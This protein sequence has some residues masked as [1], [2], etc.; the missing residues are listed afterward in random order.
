MEMLYESSLDETD[1]ELNKK[2]SPNK[3]IKRHKRKKN[4]TNSTMGTVNATVVEK[5]TKCSG[6]HNLDLAGEFWLKFP[7]QLLQRPGYEH[8][9]IENKAIHTKN[10]SEN[11]YLYIKNDV[12]PV[13]NT[14]CSKLATD[15][16][17]SAIYDRATGCPITMPNEYLN[18]S[19]LTS[20][21]KDYHEK[22]VQAKLS[23][24]NKDLQ[25]LLYKNKI[26]MYIRFQLLIAN[27]DVQQIRA[28]MQNCIKNKRGVLY[29]IKQISLAA[30][31]VYQ[32]KKFS[33]CDIDL[34]ILVLRIGGPCLLYAFNKENRLPSS[35]F[36]YKVK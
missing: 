1:V 36:I 22:M 7:F 14:Q 24:L 33:Q 6:Y 34:G 20:K 28:I 13:I 12:S 17:L 23:D 35:S 31:K 9:V 19:Q 30:N 25:L 26:A 32:P 29:M 16:K 4:N 11:N 3:T 15:T 27:N 21:C 10:C 2:T 8:L 18:Y 5:P